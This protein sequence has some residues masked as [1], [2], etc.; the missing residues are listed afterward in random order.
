M[1]GS[2]I[3]LIIWISTLYSNLSKDSNLLTKT[4][5]EGRGNTLLLAAFINLV[6]ELFAATALYS[7][8]ILTEE[9]FVRIKNRSQ[10]V[11]GLFTEKVTKKPHHSLFGIILVI[12]LFFSSASVAAVLSETY[13]PVVRIVR[14]LMLYLS[15]ML[16]NRIA[17]TIWEISRI[18]SD[19]KQSLD[20]NRK[21][22]RKVLQLFATDVGKLIA[23]FNRCN[24]FPLLIYACR[25]LVTNVTFVHSI[26]YLVSTNFLTVYIT[27]IILT[28]MTIVIINLRFWTINYFC[29]SSTKAFE[30]ILG[31]FG[32][33][34][35]LRDKFSDNGALRCL[36]L[37]EISFNIYGLF[38][39]NREFAFMVSAIFV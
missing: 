32:N 25:L 28:L 9:L 30:S 7:S 39:L 29:E 1:F 16:S 13:M 33:R 20:T 22:N 6:C 27:N 24:R 18:T 5:L 37:K 12:N 11:R 38:K 31:K 34:R 17:L 8:A 2:V 26:C 36:H 35:I 15:E 19:I 23:D 14:F 10:Y 21:N 4:V 3:L